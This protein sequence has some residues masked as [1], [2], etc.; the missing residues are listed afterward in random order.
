[1]FCDF[2]EVRVCTITLKGIKAFW[3]HYYLAGDLA[4]VDK[5]SKY[6]V[7]RGD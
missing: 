5:D 4:G 7:W 1:M 2:K 3:V 6:Y